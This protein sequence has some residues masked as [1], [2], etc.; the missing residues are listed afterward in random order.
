MWI[1]WCLGLLN[2]SDYC[3]VSRSRETYRGKL[4]TQAPAGEPI[5]CST[6][7]EL[8]MNVTQLYNKT[9]SQC[10]DSC[11]RITVFDHKKYR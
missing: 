4:Q 5:L 8:I 6:L 10:I 11:F 7:V 1:V 3:L 2:V 9:I